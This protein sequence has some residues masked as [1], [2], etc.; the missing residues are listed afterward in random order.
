[1]INKF[2]AKVYSIDP[3]PRS[4]NH[5]NDI[6]LNFGKKNKTIFNEG[7]KLSVFNY[8]LEKTNKQNF[9]F[10]N[11]A[12]WKKIIKYKTFFQKSKTR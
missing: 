8:N 2:D 1:M 5:Y 12:I 6:K 10:I 9:I 3:T 7:G 4:L 11:K